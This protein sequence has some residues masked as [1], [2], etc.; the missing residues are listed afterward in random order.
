MQ[1]EARTLCRIRGQGCEL[2][3]DTNRV[4]RGLIRPPP[5]L[6]G[7]SVCISESARLPEQPGSAGPVAGT[8]GRFSHAFEGDRGQSSVPDPAQQEKR[9]GPRDAGLAVIALQP[10]DAGALKRG[11]GDSRSSASAR[12]IPNPFSTRPSASAP[13]PIPLQTPAW[14]FRVIDSLNRSGSDAGRLEL[15]AQRAE[16]DGEALARGLGRALGPEQLAEHLAGGLALAMVGQ[17]GEQSARLL[18]PE[19]SNRSLSDRGSIGQAHAQPAEE[20]DPAARFHYRPHPSR[21]PAIAAWTSRRW[22][23]TPLP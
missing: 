17:I 22:P 11:G 15:V 8:P 3:G 2:E 20:F 5:G 16:G 14:L 19:A 13:S 18:G 1:R 23:G 21:P 9:L 6:T 10:E 7:N 12:R 4:Q